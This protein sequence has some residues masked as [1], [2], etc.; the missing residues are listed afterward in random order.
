MQLKYAILHVGDMSAAVAFY[1][2]TIGLS[3]RFE[4]PFWS[5][6]DTGE[7]TLALHPASE[8]HPAGTVRLGLGAPDLAAF[9][10]QAAAAGVVFT[11]EPAM[12]RG[13]MM[14]RFLDSEGAECAISG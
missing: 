4:S 11:M 7:A 14:A 10:R 5:E 8:R 12:Q 9:H 6:F 2:D 3:L 1:R 13:V